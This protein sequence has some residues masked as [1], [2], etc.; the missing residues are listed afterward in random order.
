MKLSSSSSSDEGVAFVGD[1]PSRAF[2]TTPLPNVSGNRVRASDLS[3]S[4]APLPRTRSSIQ[5][6]EQYLLSNIEDSLPAALTSWTT[7]VSGA[8]PSLRR[9][10][11]GANEEERQLI[12][13]S[14]ELPVPEGAVQ[15]VI[16]KQTGF[17]ASFSLIKAVVGAASFSLPWAFLQAGM[18]GG[19]VGIFIL[20]VFSWYTILQLVECKNSV[21]SLKGRYVTYPD[22]A[23]EVLGK[24]AGVMLYLAIVITSVGAC[25]AYLSLCSSL[26]NTVA[27]DSVLYKD[28]D[29]GSNWIFIVMLAAP[30]VLLS[31]IRSF[32]YLSFTSVLGDI[33]LVVGMLC[34]YIEGFR[35]N[36][37]DPS[38]NYPA[39]KIETFPSFFGNAAFLFCIHMLILPVEQSMKKPQNF[40]PTASI[41]F[42]VVT[43]LNVSFATVGYLLF[44]KDTENNVLDNLS[45]NPFVDTTRVLLVFDLFFTYIVVLVPSRDIIETSLLSSD[46]DKE[47][48]DEHSINS[49]KRFS[50]WK[51]FKRRFCIKFHSIRRSNAVTRVLLSSG[52]ARNAIRALLVGITMVIAGAFSSFTTIIGLVSG[53]ALSFMAFILPALLHMKIYWE[54]NDRSFCAFFK[55]VRFYIDVFFVIFG[56]ITAVTTTTVT[57]IDIVKNGLSF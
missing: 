25:S 18:F 38:K 8:L 30:L 48:G 5:E 41:S 9:R 14:D 32:R 20:G 11:Y 7:Y 37:V 46:P 33:C 23:K 31:W 6:K 29:D 42:I 10:T 39:L 49:V 15:K 3:Y 53:I 56:C 55:S 36:S 40:A 12:Q 34:L 54:K 57:V 51:D 45:D 44:G 16:A 13:R 21:D 19:L 2:H 1:F 22:L 24:F 17:Q 35:N 43:L 4:S 50:K 52:M 26:L 27:R 47:G 28:P